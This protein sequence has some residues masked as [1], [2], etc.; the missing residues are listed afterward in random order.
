MPEISQPT[1]VKPIWPVRR[2]D[3]KGKPKRDPEEESGDKP[4]SPSEG[5]N[6]GEGGGKEGDHRI[7]E[8]A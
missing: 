1:P 6:G 4:V 3:S 2:D 5:E 8:Y 7:D